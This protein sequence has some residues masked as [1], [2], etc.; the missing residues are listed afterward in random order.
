MR[1][2]GTQPRVLLIEDNALIG[3]DLGDAFAHAGYRVAGPV[4]TLAEA[5]AQVERRTPDLAVVDVRLKDGLCTELARELHRRGVPFLVHSACR[6]DSSLCSELLEAP[7]LAK[8]AWSPDVVAAVQDLG[9]TGAR[10]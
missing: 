4:A 10:P 1:S 5:A 3:L 2:T 7:W 8:P 9:R 6:Q